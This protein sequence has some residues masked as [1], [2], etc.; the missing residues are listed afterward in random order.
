MKTARPAPNVPQYYT[1]NDAAL[2][3]P[4]LA[5]GNTEIW[6]TN[7]NA[8][9]EWMR[10]Y[11]AIAK[12]GLIPT[13]QTLKKTH[14]LVGKIKETNPDRIF[15]AM[16]GENWSPRGEAWD[17]ISKS[18]AGHTSMSVGDIIKIG[19]KMILVDRHGFVDLI[20][21]K[22][23]AAVMSPNDYRMLLASTTYVRGIVW[24]KNDKVTKVDVDATIDQQIAPAKDYT[25]A[26][27]DVAAVTA[28]YTAKLREYKPSSFKAPHVD[29]SQKRG[30]VFTSTYF[31]PPAPRNEVVQ[32]L[33]KSGVKGIRDQAH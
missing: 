26:M 14:A 27:S 4:G 7:R 9:F 24:S 11:D 20:T 18:G 8:A 16:Q 25:E 19:N 1:L 33:I 31:N 32:A 10:G 2:Y 6:Y 28:S 22:K 23:M 17:M 15:S 5:K 21:G 30:R 12:L 29:V 3:I 13:P